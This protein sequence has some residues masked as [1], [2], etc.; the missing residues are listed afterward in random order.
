ML[1]AYRLMR[2][3]V[4]VCSDISHNPSCRLLRIC[5]QLGA[6]MAALPGCDDAEALE[7]EVKPALSMLL[8][9]SVCARHCGVASA[10]VL[11]QCIL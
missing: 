9:R 3:C 2:A 1:I 4:C 8:W 7:T 10:G 5:V 6:C 11:T